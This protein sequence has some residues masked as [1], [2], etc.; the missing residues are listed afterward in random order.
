MSGRPT[1]N[2]RCAVEVVLDSSLDLQRLPRAESITR[3]PLSHTTYQ[4]HSKRIKLDLRN[5]PWAL[6]TRGSLIVVSIGYRQQAAAKRACQIRSVTPLPLFAKVV[7][8][9]LGGRSLPGRVQGCGWL[10]GSQSALD[11]G[12]S[13]GCWPRLPASP[14]ATHSAPMAWVLRARAPAARLI[15]ASRSGLGVRRSALSG[16]RPSACCTPAL[17]R[18]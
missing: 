13:A 8:V 12:G 18:R 7:S 10:W 6:T 11:A 15:A 4:Y 3:I 9:A 2:Q 16:I 1:P 14:R 5:A 17:H